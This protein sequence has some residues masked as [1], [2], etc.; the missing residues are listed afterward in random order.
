VV[1]TALSL[2]IALVV[3]NQ[4]GIVI[5]QPIGNAICKNHRINVSMRKGVIRADNVYE[6]ISKIPKQLKQ[7]IPQQSQLTTTK[8]K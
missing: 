5:K 4:S 2:A 8:Q 3:R 6:P 1:I 7:I